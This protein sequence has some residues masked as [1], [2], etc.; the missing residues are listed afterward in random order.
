M[1]D[2]EIQDSV[3]LDNI[4]NIA[5]KLGLKDEDISLF[6]DRMAKIK[7]KF[8]NPKGRLI[9]VTAMNPT[10]SGEG[11]T[12]VSIGLADALSEIGKKVCLALREPSLGPVFGAKGGATGGGYSQV[13]PMLDI[14]LHFTGD[15]H[16]ITS[17]NNLLCSIIDNHIFQGNLL[18][19]DIDK[20]MFNRCLDL[21]DRALRDITITIDKKKGII[22]K[23]R[24]N[25]TPASE[26]M[27]ILCL[28]SDLADLKR[29]L[30]DIIVAQNIDGEPIYARDLKADEAMTILLKDAIKPNIVQTLAHTPAIIHGG[31]FANIAHGCNSIIATILRKLRRC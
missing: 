2:I 15:F 23:D 30:G 5:S 26:I 11:K 7:T 31:P 13:C 17:A 3:T 9:L 21:N 12:T 8:N 6:G 1:T 10:K 24:F 28:S 16:A 25:I 29:R 14:N 22:R 27:A 19:I 4:Q 20:V 18:N